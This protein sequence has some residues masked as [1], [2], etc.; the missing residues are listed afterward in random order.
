M[1]QT[2]H[3]YWIEYSCEDESKCVSSGSGKQ[4]LY[5]NDDFHSSSHIVSSNVVNTLQL[6]TRLAVHHLICMQREGADM[7]SVL[8]AI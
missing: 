3:Q 1:I 8:F 4:V 5:V 7:A 2:T 6:P